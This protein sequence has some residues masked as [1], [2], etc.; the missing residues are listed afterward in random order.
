MPILPL[1]LALH[2]PAGVHDLAS[3]EV[4][5]RVFEA[6]SAKVLTVLAPGGQPNLTVQYPGPPDE[7]FGPPV[8]ASVN[9]LPEDSLSITL[10]RAAP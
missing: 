10:T 2:K 1:L 9:D 7:L 8:S 6:A 3:L 5:A 4:L